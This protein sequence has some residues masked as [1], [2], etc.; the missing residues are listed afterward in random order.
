MEHADFALRML[1]IE[2][3]TAK[4]HC[5]MAKIYSR[6]MFPPRHSCLNSVIWKSCFFQLVGETGN[7]RYKIYILHHISLMKK[8]L[9]SILGLPLAHY[10]CYNLKHTKHENIN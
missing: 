5:S 1:R 7:G 6:V 10:V 4:E 8:L 2:I 9:H 3:S